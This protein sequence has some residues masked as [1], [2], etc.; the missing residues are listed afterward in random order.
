VVERIKAVLNDTL[1]KK[2]STDVLEPETR[3]TVLARRYEL[4]KWLTISNGS[5]GEN[6]NIVPDLALAALTAGDPIGKSEMF[7]NSGTTRFGEAYFGCKTDE[8]ILISLLSQ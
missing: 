7:L 4:R 2:R 5:L 8:L 1:E 6:H 3:E